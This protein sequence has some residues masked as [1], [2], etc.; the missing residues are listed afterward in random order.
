MPRI[1]AGAT[2]LVH[3]ADDEG[4]AVTPLEACALGPA[5]VASRL[6]A[7][8]EALGEEADYVDTLEAIR[9]PGVLAR[10]L[11]LGFERFR[12]PLRTKA[13]HAVATRHTWSGNARKT[14]EVWRHLLVTAPQK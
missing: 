10:A 12:D 5:I 3:L 6:P 9:D 13:R 14:L 4:T 8:E 1:V 2:L 7:F 11:E